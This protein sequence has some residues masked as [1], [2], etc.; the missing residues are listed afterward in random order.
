MSHA[1]TVPNCRTSATP[2]ALAGSFGFVQSGRSLRSLPE[3]FPN[4]QLTNLFIFADIA[5]PWN[6]PT[7]TET[8][9]LPRSVG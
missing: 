5:V 2:D 4:G 8:N 3:H 6:M 7:R 1:P 9:V